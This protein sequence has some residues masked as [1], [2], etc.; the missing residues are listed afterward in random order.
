MSVTHWQR[1]FNTGM[2]RSAHTAM[3]R[4]HAV[5]RLGRA[6]APPMRRAHAP[7]RRARWQWHSARRRDATN[8][9][10]HPRSDASWRPRRTDA[11][12]RRPRTDASRPRYDV[13]RQRRQQLLG[14]ESGSTLTD[15]KAL[16]MR[17]T[18]ARANSPVDSDSPDLTTPFQAQAQHERNQRHGGLHSVSLELRHDPA[19]LRASTGRDHCWR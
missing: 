6:I 19:L 1:R 18:A 5:T 7:M 2:T 13:T 17:R 12:P 14:C 10:T 15:S 8:T 16:G 4:A 3:R 11:T 9:R